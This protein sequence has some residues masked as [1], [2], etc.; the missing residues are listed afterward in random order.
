MSVT[1]RCLHLLRM[2]ELLLQ[3]AGIA[4]AYCSSGCLS[5]STVRSGSGGPETPALGLQPEAG[6]ISGLVYTLGVGNIRWRC[7]IHRR[8]GR[9]SAC[10]RNL[11]GGINPKGHETDDLINEAELR[12]NLRGAVRA[13]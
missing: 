11:H 13:L 10:H 7:G 8:L 2:R 12:F 4:E 5:V 3:S 6:V 9:G 1:G